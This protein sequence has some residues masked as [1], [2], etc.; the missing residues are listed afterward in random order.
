MKIRDSN[1]VGIVLRQ[2]REACGWSQEE[3]A[4]QIGASRHWV[5]AVEKGKASAEV[6]LVLKALAAL[7][8]QVDLLA[9]GGRAVQP[10]R[11]P[12]SRKKPMGRTALAL[13]LIDLDL[14][15][16]T[17]TGGSEMSIP[18]HGNG[19]GRAAQTRNE[20]GSR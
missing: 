13:E 3:L 16:R 12:V 17:N 18:S 7:H 10:P 6:G 4:H 8:L 2:A 15:L 14:V 1:D 11:R 9:A 5:L 20:K 19:A